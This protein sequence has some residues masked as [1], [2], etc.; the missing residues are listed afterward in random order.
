[1]TEHHALRATLRN[2]LSQLQQRLEK[3]ERNLR[4]P[5]EPDSEERA[6]SRENDDV[7]E[8]LDESDREEIRQLQDAISHIDAGTYGLCT[9]CGQ[10]IPPARLAALPY[11]ST[12]ITCAR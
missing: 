3:V 4:Q 2:K 5:L 11:A 8:R 7:L 9:R 10:N 1:M 6:V 12:C